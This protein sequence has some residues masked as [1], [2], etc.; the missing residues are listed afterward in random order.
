MTIRPPTPTDLPAIAAIFQ[1]YLGRATLRL[2]SAQAEDFAPYLPD[3]DSGYGLLLGELAGEIIGYAQVRPYSPRAG[4]RR[5]GLTSV[6][7]DPSHTGRGY[8]RP[9]M[10]GL[11]ALAPELGYR[12][13]SAQV[14]ADNAV[15]IALHRQLGYR[16]V[17][18]QYGIGWVDDKPV[19]VTI[20]EALLPE[21]FADP[22]WA[23]AHYHTLL[24]QSWHYRHEDI[25]HGLQPLKT[26]ESIGYVTSFLEDTPDYLVADEDDRHSM[27]AHQASWV[28]AALGTSEAY[29]R[30]R[31]LA[32]A[33][34]LRPIVRTELQYRLYQLRQPMSTE[35]TLSLPTVPYAEYERGLPQSGRHVLGHVSDERIVVYQ[36]FIHQIADYA[37][38]HQQ[39]GGPHYS[40]SRMTWIKPNFLWM[41]Y[42]S[43]WATKPNQERILAIYLP[44]AVF[45]AFLREGVLSSY[46]PGSG[47]SREAWSEQIR[48]SDVR[49]QW[50]PDHDLHG[51]PLERKAIQVGLRRAA[52]AQFQSAIERIE[53]ITPFVEAQRL[54]RRTRGREPVRVIRES[55]IPV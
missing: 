20:M 36:A 14:W 54:N 42:R 10:Q 43:G 48:H 11:L 13:L 9:L 32:S 51:R 3:G 35:F 44:L 53:D 12:H 26:P 50:D 7:L 46:D 47:L 23:A 52:L 55:V 19:D 49:L 8:G 2:G 21:L 22:A 28:L 33:K 30:L 31:Y 29:E 6:F 18:T 34:Q 41:M 5:A 45:T 1:L 24:L 40:Q 25:L 17:G 27:I 38:A 4:Y 39:F 15:S 16:V 37:V